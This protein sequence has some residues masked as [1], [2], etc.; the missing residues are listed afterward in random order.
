VTTPNVKHVN[1]GATHRPT[2]K[3]SK[4]VPVEFEVDSTPLV[5][6]LDYVNDSG[7]IQSSD[8][9][10]CQCKIRC[11]ILTLHFYLLFFVF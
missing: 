1:Y 11:F 4:H 6:P 8:S 10:Q 9:F 5:V 7:V 2:Q 3:L